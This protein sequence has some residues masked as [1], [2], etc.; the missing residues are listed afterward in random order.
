MYN[1]SD[2]AYKLN[3]KIPNETHVRVLKHLSNEL[4]VHTANGLGW[5]NSDFQVQVLYQTIAE[6]RK[7]MKHV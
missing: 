2:L 3:T 1:M 4:I 6:V 7:S 5:R